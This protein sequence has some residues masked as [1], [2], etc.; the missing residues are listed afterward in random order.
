MRRNARIG[1]ALLAFG[2]TVALGYFGT[3]SFGVIF[4]RYFLPLALC[5]R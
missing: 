4:K 5:V 3:V 1:S 2:S